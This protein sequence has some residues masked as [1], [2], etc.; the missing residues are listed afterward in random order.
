[1]IIAAQVLGDL[2]N[3]IRGQV[4]QGPAGIAMAGTLLF[5]M[6]RLSDRA[7]FVVNPKQIVYA[8]GP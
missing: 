4:V 1:M 6:T 7:T 2:F 8:D 3:V 5:Y